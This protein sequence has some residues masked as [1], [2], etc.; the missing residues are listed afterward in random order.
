MEFCLDSLKPGMQAVV[1]GFRCS[2]AMQQR[3]RDFAMVEGTRVI[4]RYRSPGGDVMALG[5]RGTTL[6]VRRSDLAQIVAR[7]V[8]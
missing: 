7:P 5:L 4:C 3:L 6:A 8:Q 2:R 1:T